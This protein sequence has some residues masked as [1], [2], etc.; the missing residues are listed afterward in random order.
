[1]NKFGI[2]VYCISLIIN[3]GNQETYVLTQPPFFFYNC[4]DKLH[5]L[6]SHFSHLQSEIGHMFFFNSHIL[7]VCEI[8]RIPANPGRKEWCH[9]RLWLV[10]TRLPQGMMRSAGSSNFSVPGCK[11]VRVVV[12]ISP[13]KNWNLFLIRGSSCSLNSCSQSLHPEK[14]RSKDFSQI[15]MGTWCHWAV[16]A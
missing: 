6:G 13:A 4:L 16:R 5:L 10:H 1:M 9:P 12:W 3:S 7:R 14:T 15:H 8:V 11:E 2:I